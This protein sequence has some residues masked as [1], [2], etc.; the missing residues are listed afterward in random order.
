MLGDLRNYK[1]CLATRRGLWR[2]G[3]IQLAI[4]GASRDAGGLKEKIGDGDGAV[5]MRRFTT[6]STRSVPYHPST[7]NPSRF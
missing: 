7:L 2:D 4:M 5:K 1:M 6:S 3:E